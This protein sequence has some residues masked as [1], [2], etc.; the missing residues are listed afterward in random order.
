M[1]E[2][3]LLV[4]YASALRIQGSLVA[5]LDE[6]GATE[7]A[8]EVLIAEWSGGSIHERPGMEKPVK[9]EEDRVFKALLQFV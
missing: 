1:S 5:K 3:V 7:Q 9:G 2:M 8:K 6:L 4:T